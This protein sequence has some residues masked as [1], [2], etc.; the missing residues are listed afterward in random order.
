MALPA[1]KKDRAHEEKM[2]RVVREIREEARGRVCGDCAHWSRGAC[3][4]TMQSVVGD[5]H[6]HAPTAVACK[7]WRRR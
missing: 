5:L 7:K 6:E 2:R 3:E 4:H 1:H